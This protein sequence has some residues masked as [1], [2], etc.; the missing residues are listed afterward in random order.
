MISLEH[1]C[2]LSLDT[3][4]RD[5]CMPSPERRWTYCRGVADSCPSSGPSWYRGKIPQ[6]WLE[7]NKTSYHLLTE[8]VGSYYIKSSRRA[9]VEL[10]LSVYYDTAPTN[11]SYI[12][13]ALA[14]SFYFKLHSKHPTAQLLAITLN[15]NTCWAHGLESSHSNINIPVSVIVR[16]RV[17]ATSCFDCMKS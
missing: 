15:E 5:P 12:P 1:S 16:K 14:Y 3:N 17:E 4:I 10:S 2:S 8:W 11:T 7:V 9:V 13:L 6:N